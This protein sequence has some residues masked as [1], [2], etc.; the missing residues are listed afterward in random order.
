[1]S[2]ETDGSNPRN[3]RFLNFYY[4]ETAS[5]SWIL[6]LLC[7]SN[8]LNSCIRIYSKDHLVIQDAQRLLM[9]LTPVLQLSCTLQLLHSAKC[10]LYLQSD[11]S[12]MLHPSIKLRSRVFEILK[13][14]YETRNVTETWNSIRYIWLALNPPHTKYLKITWLEDIRFWQADTKLLKNKNVFH[15]FTFS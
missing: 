3:G 11:S 13:R 7:L 1:M 8:R 14:I 15:S 10:Q 4:R 2:T 12:K 6:P 5:V 9:L